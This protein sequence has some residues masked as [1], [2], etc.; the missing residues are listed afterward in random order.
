MS[1]FETSLSYARAA[2]QQDPLRPYREQFLF[3]ERPSGEPYLYLCGNSLGLQ[4][5]QTRQYV[6]DELDDWAALGVEGH[7]QARHPWLSYH[8]FLT[9]P[10]ARMVGGQ[11]DETIVMNGLTVNLHLLM[12]TFY[13]PSP[14]RYKILIE[15]DAFPSDIYAV[16]S[17]LA[18]HGYD[19]TEG[20]LKLTPR[21]GAHCLETEDIATVLAQHGSDIAL[22]LMGGV[23]YYTGQLFDIAEITRLAQAQGCVV[24]WDL[25]HAVGNVPLHLH[26]WNVDFAAWCTYK[27]LNSG[28]GG[29]AGAFIHARHATNTD[30]PR[31]AGWWGHDKATRFEMGPDFRAI[32]TVEGWQLSNAPVLLMAALRASLAMFDEVGMPALRAKSEKLTGYLRHL[33]QE[34]AAHLNLSVITPESPAERGCQLSLLTGPDG[35]RLFDYLSRHGVICDW[36]E[37]NVIRVAPTPFY[38]SFEDVWR[39]VDLLVQADPT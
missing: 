25:A 27:Y 16:S 37:P 13:R 3:P 39:L 14:T 30:L 9:K 23:N 31:L 7:T 17:Q 38:N 26:D 36:R 24:G 22:V 33:L 28:P 1:L 11:P 21:P 15:A 20:L 6:L 18:W 5:R 32:P 29:V 2:D 12:A 10:M 35:K 19:P 8:E 4:P 34:R